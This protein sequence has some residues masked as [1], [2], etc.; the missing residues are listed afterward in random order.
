MSPGRMHHHFY[1][2]AALVVAALMMTPFTALAAECTGMTWSWRNHIFDVDLVGQDRSTNPIH[3]DTSCDVSLPILCLHKEGQDRPIYLY[4]DFTNGW[5]GGHIKLTPPHFGYELTSQ[6]TADQICAQTFGNGWVMGEYHDGGRGSGWYAYGSISYAGRFWV[7]INDQSANPW[8]H[9]LL[10]IQGDVIQGF[11][12]DKTTGQPVPLAGAKVDAGNG[13][14]AF[15][16]ASGHYTLSGLPPGT[17]TLK[18]SMEGW[19]FGSDAFQSA[20]DT[21]TVTADGQGL[22]MQPIRGWDRDP[23]VFVHGWYG[24][25]EQFYII[26]DV[27]RDNGYYTIAEHLETSIVKTPPFEVNALKV[28]DWV[29][30]AKEVT[31]RAKVILYAHSMGGLVAR[32]YVEG[33]LYQGDVS[34]I[35]TFGSPHLGTPNPLSYL[36]CKV[37]TQ[38]PDDLCEMIKQLK[39]APT[40]HPDALCEMSKPGMENFNLTHFKRSGVAYHLIAGNA[41]MKMTLKKCFKIF[42]KNLC[43]PSME[44]PDS[45]YRNAV[46]WLTGLAIKAPNDGLIETCSASGVAGSAIDRYITHEVHHAPELGWRDY[47]SWNSDL[48][49]EGFGNCAKRILIDRNAVACGS[50]TDFG[51]PAECSVQNQMG[52]LASSQQ[53]SASAPDQFARMNEG[54]IHAGEHRVRSVFIEGG[55]TAFSASW[56]QGT[57]HFTLIDPS[58]KV[59]DPAYAASIQGD[60][61]DPNSEEVTEPDPD[62]VIYSGDPAHAT[63]YFPMARQGTWQLVLDGDSDIPTEGTSFTDSASLASPLAA[64]FSSDRSSYDP[65]SEA[66]LSV[67]FSQPL[68]AAEVQ[69][70]VRFAGDA[71]ENVVLQQSSA[72]EY[73]GR[74]VIPPASGYASFD[75][76]VVG[77]RTDGVA[78]ERGGQELI[79]IH[80][81]S[82]RLGSG[83]TDGAIPREDVPELNSALAVH[84]QVQSDYGDGDLGA[85][86]E[87]V[88]ADGSVVARS[89]VSAP[90]HVGVNDVE[91]RFRAEDIYRSKA[92]GPYTVRNVRLLDQHNAPL[93]SQEIALAYTTQAYSYLSFAPSLGTP[94]VFLEG[95]F[96]VNAGETLQL[97]ATGIDPEGDPLSYAWDLDADGN[98][99]LSG[100]SVPFT[101]SSQAPSGLRTIRV[102]VVDPAGNTAVGEAQV[103]VLGVSTNRPPVAR[104]HDVTVPADPV[105]GANDSVDDGS[106]DPDTGD[107]FTCVQTAGEPDSTGARQV[108]LTCTDAGG[109]S[110]SCDATVTVKEWGPLTLALN[111][112]SEMTLECGV[113]TWSDPGAQAWDSCGPL[114]V[115]RYNSGQDDYGPGPN[116]N[117]EGSYSVQYSAWSATGQTV[118]AIRTV[119]VDD[120]TAPTLTLKGADHMTHPCGSAWV[121]PGVEAMDAC[122]GDLSAMVVRSGDYVNG[123][124]PGVYTV[125]YVLTDSGGNSA[126]PV[127]RTVEVGACPW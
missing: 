99:E 30:Q 73:T 115:H 47:F 34:Q 6:A 97:T 76:S 55:A 32:A 109:L 91:L 77:Q 17:Y 56:E 11:K 65:G 78:F 118:S 95:P 10:G 62:A 42:N 29:N 112:D 43:L 72:T 120:R 18:T 94:T 4:L 58:G 122:Y 111:G 2:L 57:V 107:R 41:P 105:C 38:H 39:C 8:N 69:V 68:Q 103:E 106:Y 46:G 13:H 71:S 93:L 82:V 28:R 9:T 80:S 96:R 110:S 84:L 16:D 1:V 83:H 53:A 79:Q 27:L 33:D 15:T 125:R 49:Q 87:L 101:A 36:R 88:A 126:T 59:I 113:D 22:T 74:Y 70:T 86:A 60:P 92:D 52:L 114:E 61:N 26:P 35:F 117:A 75:W 123:W 66:Q 21:T 124:V 37:T 25:P 51:P 20:H 98:F 100:Q 127:T 121:D 116:V 81:T 24:A 63:Y 3:G 64:R 104:C 44:L 54:M 89:V 119:H 85:F 23:V 19:T 102:K 108:T 67:S 7:A 45:N 40:Q 90:A 12:K 50:L 31:G 48:S 5:A 14:V